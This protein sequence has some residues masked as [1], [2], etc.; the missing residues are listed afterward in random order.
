MLLC[1]CVLDR[2]RANAGHPWQAARARQHALWRRQGNTLTMR[3]R[4]QLLPLIRLDEVVQ[5]LLG[6]QYQQVSTKL[7]T[8]NMWLTGACLLIARACLGHFL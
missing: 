5:L 2:P 1:H 6:Q 4:Q 8:R 7:L 3:S